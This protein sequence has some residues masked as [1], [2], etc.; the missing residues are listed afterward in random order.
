MLKGLDMKATSVATVVEEL[1]EP[2]KEILS[3]RNY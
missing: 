1:L 3:A 2:P